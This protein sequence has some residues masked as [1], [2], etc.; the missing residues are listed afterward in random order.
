MRFF[1]VF[2]LSILSLAAG[3]RA[4]EAAGATDDLLVF[5][6]ARERQFRVKGL[7]PLADDELAGFKGLEYFPFDARLVVKAKV[8]KASE[9]RIFLMPTSTGMSEK[10]VVYGTFVFE[11][12]GRA[13]TL[14]AYQSETIASGK[15]PS[16]KSLVFVP[17]RDLTNG[18]ETYGAGRFLDIRVTG[19][20]AVLNFNF[21]Y[22]PN[23][24][25]G[26][27]KY[28]CPVPPREN[29]L[30]AKITAGEKKYVSAKEK[31]SP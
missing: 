15:Y 8:E 31:I 11:L 30:Q 21:A 23:C 25:Y 18:K 1:A 6:E 12:E 27:N 10:Y 4:Q 9:P 16:Y 28:A 24:A 19:E 7:S 2:M 5:R 26:G 22:N 3:A 20:E 14:T 17:F 29:F 13:H